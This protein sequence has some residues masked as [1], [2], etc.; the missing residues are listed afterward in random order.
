MLNDDYKDML[1]ALSAEKVKFLLVGAYALVAH[2][3]PRATMN[4]DMLRHD[5]STSLPL[6]TA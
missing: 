3:Y 4:I 5:V 1:Q 6:L 2:G